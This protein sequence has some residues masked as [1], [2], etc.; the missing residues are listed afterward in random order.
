VLEHLR[1]FGAVLLASLLFAK[2]E[3][4]IEGPAGWAAGLPTWRVENRW[5]RLFLGRK[6]LTGYHA[7]M[8]GTLAFLC[9]VP[10]FV[11]LAA[12]TARSEAR[13]MSFFILFCIVEDFLW[14]ALNPAFGLSRFKAD[15]VWWHRS[16]WWLFA[17]RD[18]FVFGPVAIALYWYSRTY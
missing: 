1:F 6:P 2:A 9:H 10:Y 4:N 7:Y 14:F 15:A 17:P 11:G 5:T 8:F 16:T 12:L 3:I 18:Y 13:V